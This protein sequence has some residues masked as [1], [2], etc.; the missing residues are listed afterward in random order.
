MAKIGIL[1]GTG[2]YD[3]EILEG[4]RTMDVSTPFGKPSDSITTGHLGHHELFI[5]PRHGSRHT[6]NP[7]NVNYRANI[8]A[9]KQLGVTHILA[10]SA[11]GSLREDFK[12]GDIVLTDQFIDRTAGRRSS[13]YDG[14]INS[15]L[16][17]S[18][19]AGQR[20]CHISVAEPA[21]SHLRKI[22]AEEAK[23]SGY[24]HHE[25]GTIVVIEGPRFSTKAESRLFRSWGA[26]IIGMTMVPEC[27]L[28]REAEICYASIATVTDYDVWLEGREVSTEAILATMKGSNLRVKGL[29]KAAIPRIKD[30]RTCTCKDALKGAFV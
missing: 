22:L 18:D 28:A 10:P 15:G 1:G 11:V 3:P 5:L 23:S 13:F 24:R 2:V 25:S 14:D 26:D 4:S 30:E 8:H 16:S 20:V 17:Q 21:C 12:P 7:G 9:L 27:I 19:K 29:L 6:I